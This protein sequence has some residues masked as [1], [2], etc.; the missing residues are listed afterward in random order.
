MTFSVCFLW[1]LL[2]VRT[3]VGW[4]GTTSVRE[5]SEGW[6]NTPVVSVEPVAG[7]VTWTTLV[8]FQM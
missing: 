4:M 6:E 8:G 7:D 2:W 1:G 3:A 5:D